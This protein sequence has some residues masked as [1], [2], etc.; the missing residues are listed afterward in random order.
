MPIHAD[1]CRPFSNSL[2]SVTRA[3]RRR[4]NARSIPP[5]GRG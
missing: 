4:A 3:E 5:T 2:A 1:R